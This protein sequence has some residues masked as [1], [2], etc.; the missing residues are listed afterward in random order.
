MTTR[1]HKCGKMVERIC[2][3]DK[4][5]F[6]DVYEK[7]DAYFENE[8]SSMVVYLNDERYNALMNWESKTN[9]VERKY[10]ID[11]F[12]EFRYKTLGTLQAKRK[13]IFGF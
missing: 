5:T 1:F 12:L 11:Q 9:D 8:S 13:E 7:R 6:I 3:I 10:A 2:S 4:M